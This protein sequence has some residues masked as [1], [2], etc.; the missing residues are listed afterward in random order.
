MRGPSGTGQGEDQV[1]RPSAPPVRVRL[2]DGQEITGRL[3]RR[4]QGRE[5]LWFYECEVA[6]WAGAEVGGRDVAEPA[7]VTFTAPASHVAPVPGVSYEGV[8]L[9]R[10]PAVIARARTGSR[11]ARP[12]PDAA[13]DTERWSVEEPR[14]SADAPPRTIVHRD[15]CFTARGPAKLTTAQ[16]LAALRRPGAEACPACGAE[17]LLTR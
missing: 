11:H 16:A 5:G 12:R 17:R 14:R 9:R 13:G 4:W 15:G 3:L 2:P 7:D 10:H 6:L 1:G 8:P